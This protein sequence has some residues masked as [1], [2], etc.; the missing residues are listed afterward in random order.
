MAGINF[1][2]WIDVKQE[3]V[4]DVPGVQHTAAWW[5]FNWNIMHERG[6]FARY[7]LVTHR[8]L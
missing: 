8:L 7:G 3:I 4:K 5:N 6:Y 2:V 1:H